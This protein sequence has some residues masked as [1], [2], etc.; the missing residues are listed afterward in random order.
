MSRLIVILLTLLGAL[1]GLPALFPSL[2]HTAFL[3]QEFPVRYSYLI[4]LIATIMAAR[5]GD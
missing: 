5:L 2:N 3:I 4:A 1:I